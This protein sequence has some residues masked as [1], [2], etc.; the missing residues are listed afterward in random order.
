MVLK[1]DDYE[2][3]IGEVV[4]RNCRVVSRFKIGGLELRRCEHACNSHQSQI[5]S[6]LTPVL[7]SAI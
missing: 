3:Y 6:A 2:H 7:R 5:S 4:R 1:K